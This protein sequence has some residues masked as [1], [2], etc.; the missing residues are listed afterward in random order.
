MR[1]VFQP[2]WKRGLDD[3]VRVVAS[4]LV[5]SETRETPLA[6]Q[7]PIGSMQSAPGSR[8]VLRFSTDAH[9][10]LLLPCDH[11]TRSR[12]SRYSSGQPGAGRMA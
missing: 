3:A 7:S 12:P 10:G 11:R 8:R 6:G 5:I 2:A 1:V 4:H 9:T